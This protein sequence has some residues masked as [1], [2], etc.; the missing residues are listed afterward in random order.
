MSK[1]SEFNE[2]Y[3]E[4][5]GHPHHI[6]FAKSVIDEQ[7][8]EIANLK[9]QVAKLTQ[10]NSGIDSRLTNSVKLHNAKVDENNGLRAHI[11]T[12]SSATLKIHQNIYFKDDDDIG[13]IDDEFVMLLAKAINKTPRQCL[14]SAKA[15]AV[16]KCSDWLLLI[17][18][19]APCGSDFER[20]I[21]TCVDMIRG[22]AEELREA[23]NEKV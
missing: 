8:Q 9:Q 19:K 14:A 20:N 11:N 7:Q 5:C 6:K 1:A 21:M 10:A 18:D 13:R 3:A 17:S 15:D 23:A 2:W 22:Y 12:L 16:K 4:H